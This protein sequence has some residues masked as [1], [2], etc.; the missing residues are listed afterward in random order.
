MDTVEIW[1]QR[2]KEIGMTNKDIS[3]KSGIPLRTIEKIMCRQTGFPRIDTAQAIEQ[4]LG[5][6]QEEITSG[7]TLSPKTVNIS[8]DEDE[9]LNLYRG[10]SKDDQATARELIWNFDKFLSHF[11]KNTIIYKN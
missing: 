3:E 8:P 2:K 9:L 11:Y 4:A 10:L 7:A 1:K 5:L 6:S